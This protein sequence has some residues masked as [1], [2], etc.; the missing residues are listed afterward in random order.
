MAA[1]PRSK[2][3]GVTSIPRAGAFAECVVADQNHVALKP[4]SKENEV[5]KTI[6]ITGC[7]S[8]IGRATANLF[9]QKGWNVVA[10]M[11]TP[12]REQELTKRENVLVTALD[13]TKPESI[14][15]A[16]NAA[17]T[18]FRRIDVLVNNAGFGAYG[19][20][21][22][23]NAESIRREFDT[24]VV[25]MLAMTKAVIPHLR[26]NREGVVV[27]IASMGGKFAFPLGALYHG[28]KFAVE[29]LSEAL[30]YEMAAIGVRV[31]I[32]EP[33]M[34]ATGFGKA[35]DFSNDERLTEYQPL[36]AKVMASFA[37]SQKAASPPEVVADVVFQAV[38]DGTD[39]LRYRVGKDTEAM[40]SARQSQDDGTF[41]Q[42][43]RGQLG[44]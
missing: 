35:M 12:Q 15:S 29:G 42:N 24:N 33:G 19:P 10:T 34:V 21:E 8:G 5:S 39:Q 37:E 7:S 13:V 41:F 31:K 25:G 4:S 6:M 22:A 27:N 40:L 30:S 14:E 38:S 26:V 1:G 44:L 36:V 17:L 20:L 18:R 9:Q 28:A 11:R 43:L 2:I 23:T 16:V 3:A 32:I